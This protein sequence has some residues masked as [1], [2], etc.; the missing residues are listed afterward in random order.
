[1]TP[2]AGHGT[3]LVLSKQQCLGF[4]LHLP[5]IVPYLCLCP[6]GSRGLV[7][8]CSTDCSSEASNEQL[9]A[10]HPATPRTGRSYSPPLGKIGPV[11]VPLSASR[12]TGE[13]STMLPFIRLL[14][15]SESVLRVV[16]PPLPG[17]GPPGTE[18]SH[19]LS[20]AWHREGEAINAQ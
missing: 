12:E 7:P 1:M 17:C 3:D 15:A 14:L 5:G 6:P 11:P 10:S 19:L 9:P 2:G 18:I 20:V 8:H 16:P 13:A 4:P